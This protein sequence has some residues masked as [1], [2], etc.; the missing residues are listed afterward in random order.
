MLRVKK[1]TPTAVL[2]IRASAKAAGY[3]LSSSSDCIVP[4]HGKALVP[5]GLIVAIPDSCYGR[6][7]NC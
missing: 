6:I 2:P 4:A 5:T 3:D 1:T 7:G